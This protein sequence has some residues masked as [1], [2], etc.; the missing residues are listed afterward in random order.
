MNLRRQRENLKVQ[1]LDTERLAGKVAD[2]P[3]MGFSLNKK[4][5]FLKQALD[6][7]PLTSKEPS[8]TLLFSGQPVFGS[9]GIDATF[10]SK[11]ILPFQ[12][13]VHSD[14][15]QRGF[16]KVGMRGQLKNAYDAK[17]F[18]TALPRGSFGV[19]L[20]KI[21]NSSL[22]DEG[23][24]SDSLSH[25]SNLIASSAKSDEDF[26]ASLD[27]IPH[28]TLS[29]LR[30]FLKIVSEDKAGVIVES[31]GIRASLE[32]KDV[33]AAYNR[34]AETTTVQKEIQL[35]GIL[36][37]IL[38]ESWR[39]DFITDDGHPISGSLGG[40]LTEDTAAT[41]FQSHFN[42]NCIGFFDMTTVFLKNGRVKETYALNSVQ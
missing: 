15:V 20:S 14:L 3:I 19:E 22:F 33:E 24:V 6:A 23:Q 30:Q 34:V 29:G 8:I 28:R 10:I 32:P 2:H 31:G 42:K 39:F 35:K 25:V 5:E 40:N 41:L 36:K 12:K 26:A 18:L 13:M 1:I 27:N 9:A 37:G 38:L 21:E 17:L 11:A 16:G 4:L 7:L